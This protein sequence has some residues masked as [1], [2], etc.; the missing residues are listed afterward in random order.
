MI[1]FNKLADKFNLKIRDNQ[2]VDFKL[3]L[4]LLKHLNQKVKSILL[5]LFDLIQL[6]GLKGRLFHYQKH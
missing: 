6:K 3:C 1:V 2:K 4:I 5:F